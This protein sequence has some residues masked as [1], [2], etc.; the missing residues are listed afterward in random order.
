[1]V[2]IAADDGGSATG[3]RQQSNGNAAQDEEQ[4]SVDRKEPCMGHAG[5]PTEQFGYGARGRAAAVRR[6]LFHRQY[7]GAFDGQRQIRGG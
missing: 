7:S 4:D 2:Q 1:M 5:A 6:H 3:L